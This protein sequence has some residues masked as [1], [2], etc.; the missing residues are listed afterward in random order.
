M[1]MRR[2]LARGLNACSERA[3]R[4]KTLDMPQIIR[5]TPASVFA[6]PHRFCTDNEQEMIPIAPNRGLRRLFRALVPKLYV[7]SFALEVFS[8]SLARFQ[9]RLERHFEDRWINLLSK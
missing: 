9:S 1:Y 4:R 3:V 7:S 8:A 5:N 6:E 2:L